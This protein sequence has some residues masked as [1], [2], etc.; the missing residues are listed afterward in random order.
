M[1]PAWPSEGSFPE[2][3]TPHLKP[4]QLILQVLHIESWAVVSMS[5]GGWSV[6]PGGLLKGEGQSVIHL[7]HLVSGLSLL[8]LV[9]QVSTHLVDETRVRKLRF[10]HLWASIIPP[11][12][13][14]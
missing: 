5:G 12:K 4:L 7:Y 9:E 10:N 13:W 11:V 1:D 8:P 6:D 2:D 14:V 3:F